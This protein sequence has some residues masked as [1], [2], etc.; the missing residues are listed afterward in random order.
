MHTVDI[1]VNMVYKIRYYV[2][3]EWPNGRAS[4]SLQDL[5][6]KVTH[7]AFVIKIFVFL[8]FL[9]GC[10]RHVFKICFVEFVDSL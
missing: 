5:W 8:S 1:C 3:F 2:N 10:L 4:D 6:A 7:G 9:S